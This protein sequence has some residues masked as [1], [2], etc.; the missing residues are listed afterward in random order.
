ME[1][2]NKSM[3]S[4][5]VTLSPEE[6]FAIS[7][8]MWNWLYEAITPKWVPTKTVSANAFI[9]KVPD[10]ETS[11]T[12]PNVYET[13]L[14]NLAPGGKAVPLNVAEESYA[15]RFIMLTIDNK[16][17]LPIQVSEGMCHDI[18]LLYDPAINSIC[19]QQMAMSTSLSV[20]CEMS[21][22]GLAQ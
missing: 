3:K 2:Y 19:N 1:I 17:A 15:L 10:E 8:D 5:L 11:I 12:V 13:Y 7:H 9:E 16:R 22:A 20:W 21:P 14:N 18:G 4:P 6:L